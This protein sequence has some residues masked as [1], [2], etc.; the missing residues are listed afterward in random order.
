MAKTENGRRRMAYAMFRRNAK[1]END[2]KS[3]V[4]LEPGSDEYLKYARD[5]AG[6][7]ERDFVDPEHVSGP[8]D[9]K[10]LKLSDEDQERERGQD[11]GEEPEHVGEFAEK[12]A[13]AGE[14]MT[15]RSQDTMDRKYRLRMAKA[16]HVGD[17]KEVLTE[18]AAT[19]EGK[20][21]DAIAR[22]VSSRTV[23]DLPDIHDDSVSEEDYASKAPERYFGG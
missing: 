3:Q 5:S 22:R 18:A 23:D 14:D 10:D 6:I 1:G 7:D 21:D 12:L 4:S 19:T 20:R 9:A 17:M 11:M 16:G 8:G 15:E 13:E 2:A